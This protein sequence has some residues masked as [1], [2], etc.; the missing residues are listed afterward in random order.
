MGIPFQSDSSFKYYITTDILSEIYH[1]KKTIDGLNLLLSIKKVNIVDP[2]LVNIRYVSNKIKS[3]GQFGLSKPDCSIIA[4]SF[5]LNLPI[6]STDY[7]VIN[8]AKILSL[9]TVIPGKSNFE[10]KKNKKYC[11]ICKKFFD[12]G[13]LY[14]NYCGNKLIY[15][16]FKDAK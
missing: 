16:I 3:L 15:K 5:Q 2:H 14:C 8:T 12:I 4:L 10:I 1:I 13:Y 6:M 11:S 9:N 7:A